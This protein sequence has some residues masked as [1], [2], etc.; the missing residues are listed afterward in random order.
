[1]LYKSKFAVSWDQ[2][3]HSPQSEYYEEIL[4]VKPVGT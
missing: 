3:K 2:K 4:N 1:M